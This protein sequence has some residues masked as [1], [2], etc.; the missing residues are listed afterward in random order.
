[1]FVDGL[2]LKGF[3]GAFNSVKSQSYLGTHLHFDFLFNE[4]HLIKAVVVMDSAFLV[5][6]PYG[7]GPNEAESFP[8]TFTYSSSWR[9]TELGVKDRLLEDRG[10]RQMEVHWLSI[11]N[12]VGLVLLLTGF[13]SIVINRIVRRDITR[14]S[15]SLE[16]GGEGK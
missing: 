1:M 2:P 15:K 6:L 16:E 8:V 9:V 3:I 11:M 14:Y 13:I 10:A 4:N 12:S 7:D 5:P